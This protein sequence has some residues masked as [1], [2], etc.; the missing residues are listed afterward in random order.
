MR[1]I[2][3]VLLILGISSLLFPSM[4]DKPSML[5]KSSFALYTSAY[6]PDPTKHALLKPFVARLISLSGIFKKSIY[7]IIVKRGQNWSL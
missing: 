4:D 5:K 6:P 1:F 7:K 3:T 2:A